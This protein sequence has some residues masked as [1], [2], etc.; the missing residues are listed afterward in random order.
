MY[1]QLHDQLRDAVIQERFCQA[2]G[3]QNQE[4]AGAPVLGDEPLILERR[5]PF[6]QLHGHTWESFMEVAALRR[7]KA[8]VEAQLAELAAAAGVTPE[9]L[10]ELQQMAE[11]LQATPRIR[12]VNS[13]YSFRR[14]AE[15]TIYELPDGRRRAVADFWEN[16]LD[17]WKQLIHTYSQYRVWDLTA[18]LK[19]LEKLQTMLTPAQFA[20][21]LLTGCFLESSRRS[22]AKYFL[23]RL[24]PTLVLLPGSAQPDADLRPSVALCLHP[25]GYY[26][27]TFAG[28]LVPTD[29]VLAHLT[30]LRGDEHAYWRQANQIPLHYANSG[31]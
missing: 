15:V 17:R 27:G 19:A 30:L 7:E 1:R 13:W 14:Q 22:H 2:V 10:A 6:Q 28:A 9:Q 5:Y 20:S 18:E 8:E 21:Y 29:D 25:I 12:E 24:R 16:L 26:G 3:E 31:L 11:Q 4:W 23:R